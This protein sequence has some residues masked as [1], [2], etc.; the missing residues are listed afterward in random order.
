MIP[1]LVHFSHRPFPEIRLPAL[2]FIKILVSH[3]WGQKLLAQDPNFLKILLDRSK[4]MDK[5]GKEAKYEVIKELSISPFTAHAF[6]REQIKLI[7]KYYREG[8][9]FV[10]HESMVSFE[11]Q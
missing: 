4:G 7:Q 6:N 3:L 2:N 9:F 5:E 8:P 1:T 11:A 10:D